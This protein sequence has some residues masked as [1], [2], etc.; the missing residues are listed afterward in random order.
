[1]S[2]KVGSSMLYHFIF[3]NHLNN[4]TSFDVVNTCVSCSAGKSC[5]LRFSMSTFVYLDPWELI[6][7]DLWDCPPLLA[8]GHTYYMSIVDIVI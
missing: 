7:I 1:M 3:L 8:N 4:I 5:K 6:E 2:S